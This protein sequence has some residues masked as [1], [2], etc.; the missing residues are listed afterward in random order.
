MFLPQHAF[1]AESDP[2]SADHGVEARRIEGDA[3]RSRDVIELVD[4]GVDVLA[5]RPAS[6]A[7]TPWKAMFE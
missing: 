1:H 5:G 2:L 6:M 4:V 3:V 7:A